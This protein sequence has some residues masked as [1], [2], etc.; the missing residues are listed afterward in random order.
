MPAYTDALGFNKGSSG[1]DGRAP[2]R[3]SLLDV[4]LDFAKIKAARL[5]AGATALAAADTLA[6]FQVPA[7]GI[8]LAGGLEVLS[9]ET[10]NTTATLSLGTAGAYAAALASNALAMGSVALAAPVPYLTAADVLLTINTA[11]PLN[12]KVRAFLLVANVNAR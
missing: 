12:A 9:A 11:V 4:T 10:T 2:D 6:I 1:F 3:V 7:G 8:V 5:A